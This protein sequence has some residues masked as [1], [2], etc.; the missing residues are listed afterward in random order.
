M[1]G[2]RNKGSGASQDVSTGDTNTEVNP[3]PSGNEMDTLINSSGAAA[4]CVPCQFFLTGRCRFGERCRN[5]HPGSLLSFQPESKPK[6]KGESEPK[7][8]KPPMKT[9]ADVIS[10]IQWDPKLPKEDF[11]IGYLDRFLGIIEKPYSAFCWE[12]LAS[13]GHDVL[14]IPKHRI[15]YFKYRD[16]VVW[17]KTS[18]TDNVFGS[19][20]S[21]LTILDIIER[22]EM[23]APKEPVATALEEPTLAD[24]DVEVGSEYGEHSNEVDESDGKVRPSHFVAVRISSEEVRS[25]VKELQNV[26]LGNNPDLA[27]FCV[28]L[29]SLHLTL[30]L[31]YLESAEDIERALLTLQELKHEMQ[32]TLPPSLILSFEGV[33]DFHSRVLYLAPSAF[34]ALE[35]FAHSLQKSFQ[36]KG[37]RVIDPPRS[38]HFHVTIAKIPMK[39]LRKQPNLAFV[40]Q[41][42]SNTPV[43]HFGAQQVDSLSF[44]Y[45]GS[46][47]RTDGFY[48]TLLELNLY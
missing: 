16:L 21:A 35:K 3:G 19:T 7:G 27:E 11:L 38:S 1:E 6:P 43:T 18:R 13:V 30:C 4:E 17:D 9:A 42:Y 31:L 47:R 28:P 48:T 26:L 14:A 46:A 33:R 36:S 5:V 2:D 40:P 22:Y 39:V 10:R 37:L 24:A 29:P 32:R 44:C 8:K 25:A 23:L 12:D 15:Q 45:A 20:G 34:P 41:V